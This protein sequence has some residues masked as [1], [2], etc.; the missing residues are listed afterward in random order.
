[1]NEYITLH[2]IKTDGSNK[3]MNASDVANMFGKKFVETVMKNGKSSN[4]MGTFYAR[5]GLAK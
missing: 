2:L 3:S 4:G 5:K 1:M